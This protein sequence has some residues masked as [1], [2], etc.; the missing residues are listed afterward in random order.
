[1]NTKHTPEC[2]CVI[3]GTRWFASE[4]RHL[5]YYDEKVA[6]CPLHKAAPALLAALEE[7]ETRLYMAESFVPLIDQQ[8]IRDCR[9]KIHEVIALATGKEG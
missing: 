1:M 5:H 3:T 2:S 9:A 8:P 4:N 6:Y 7:A